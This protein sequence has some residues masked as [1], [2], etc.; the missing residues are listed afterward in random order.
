[1]SGKRF[2]ILGGEIKRRKRLF[3]FTSVMVAVVVVFCLLR[4]DFSRKP[5]LI[6]REPRL[7][8][9]KQMPEK[10]LADLCAP[11]VDTSGCSCE[12]FMYCHMVV[13]SAVSSNH[14]QEFK[15]FV[16]SVQKFLPS[17]KILVY[18]L[19]LSDHDRSLTASYCNVKIRSFKFDK[20]PAHVS[21]L[22]MYSWKPILLDEVAR[23]YEIILYGDA[24]VRILGP[25]IYDA[26]RLLRRFPFIAGRRHKLPFMSFVHEGMLEYM[27]YPFS[28]KMLYDVGGVEANLL[29]MWANNTTRKHIV[30]PLLDCA[31]HKEC[32]S[33]EGAV[34]H[35]CAFYYPFIHSHWYRDGSYVGSHRYDQSALNLILIREFGLGKVKDYLNQTLNDALWHVD[36]TEKKFDTHI[37][38]H[39]KSC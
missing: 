34:L 11:S 32:I 37:N 2:W 22:Y 10:P 18:D 36:R 39:V 25:Y 7:S 35:G 5:A 33:P 8:C 23:E 16:G 24:S 3:L 26:F 9:C 20:Y 30:E 15:S 29:L 13:V 38:F 4:S 14:F 17:V 21:D 19:G 12:D 31:V 6:P 28:R 27:K 1:M